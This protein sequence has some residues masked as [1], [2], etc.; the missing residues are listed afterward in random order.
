MV[1]REDDKG[2]MKITIEAET[3]QEKESIPE[4]IVHENLHCH[5]L[6]AQGLKEGVMPYNASSING[7]R[8]HLYGLLAEAQ[9][10]VRHGINLS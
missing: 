8:F 10:R 1:F 7:D 3:D 5:A 4:P 9:L 6:I 2:T